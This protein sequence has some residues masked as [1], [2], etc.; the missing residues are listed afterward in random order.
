MRLLILLV[1]AVFSFST[2]TTNEEKNN[3]AINNVKVINTDELKK[4]V[5]ERNGNILFINIWATWCVPCIEEFP[6]I[7]KLYKNYNNNGI[8]FLSL[9]VD[10]VSEKESKVIPFLQKHNAEFS[11]YII[12]EKKS[13]EVI[14]FINK[15]WSGAVPVTIIYNENGEQTAFLEGL[16]SYESF[17]NALEKTMNL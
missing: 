13:E 2:C 5:A 14:N 15:E 11:T 1:I 10:L 3:N 8:D 9:S 17:K 12:D 16:Q 7:V 6:D 4:I